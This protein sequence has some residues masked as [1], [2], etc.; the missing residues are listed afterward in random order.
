MTQT[1]ESSVDI[2]SEVIT[3]DEVRNVG[4]SGVSDDEP[5][6]VKVVVIVLESIFAG[7]GEERL[8]LLSSCILWMKGYVKKASSTGEADIISKWFGHGD[9][10]AVDTF[11]GFQKDLGKV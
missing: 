2:G 9:G 6:Q 10:G 1:L 4:G 5:A 3:S 11:C 7:R 8:E